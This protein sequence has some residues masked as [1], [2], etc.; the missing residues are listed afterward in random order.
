MSHNAGLLCLQNDT[1][2]DRTALRGWRNERKSSKLDKLLISTAVV[3]VLMSLAGERSV[4][5]STSVYNHV[6]ATL[7]RV[8]KTTGNLPHLNL[9]RVTLP[10]DCFFVVL[11]LI[12]RIGIHNQNR[13]RP[14]TF[15]TVRRAN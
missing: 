12:K 15:R 6:V 4:R 14:T 2:H 9:N 11:F 7:P 5:T 3:F 8:F 1:F 10:L 13:I